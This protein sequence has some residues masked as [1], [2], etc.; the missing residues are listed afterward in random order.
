[1]AVVIRLLTLLPLVL[2]WACSP[3]FIAPGSA[4]TGEPRLAANS[5]VSFDGTELPLR[6]WLP[7][8]PIRAVCIALHGFNDYSNFIAGMADYLRGEGIAVYAYDQRGFGAAPHRG[9]WSGRQ[10]LCNDLATIT[11]LVRK[12]HPGT[13]LYLLGDSMGG[14]VV[15]AAAGAARSLP[16]DGFILVAPAVWS[17]ST[18][19]FYQRWALWLAAHTM[20]WLH[21]TGKS[22]DI[23]ASDN[24][25]M[26]KELGRDP[27]VIK[28][29]R[30]DTVYGLVNLMDAAQQ[31]ATRFNGRVLF[32]YGK[33]DEIIPP[34]AMSALFRKRLRTHF[35]Q[36]QRL[37]VYENGYHML[38]RDLQA[39]VVWQDILF[40]LRRPSGPFPSVRDRSAVEIV[41]EDDLANILPP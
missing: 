19:P 41:R 8:R 36:P 13:P 7:A 23:K 3:R 40:W 27:L 29:S 33:K 10:A 17:R 12:R 18:M 5:F 28:E 22:L 21:V 35:S 31:A 9:M 2:L 1:M 24:I 15:L 11:A 38:L 14:A 20:P 26:L 30:I 4:A 32:L 16:A 37:I 34:A 39:P 25:A 6:T